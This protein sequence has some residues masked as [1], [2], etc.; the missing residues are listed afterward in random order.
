MTTAPAMSLRQSVVGSRA[1]RYSD[2]VELIWT[3]PTQW[4]P[5]RMVSL[6]ESLQTV[7]K[8]ESSSPGGSVSSGVN[9]NSAA[10]SALVGCG[11]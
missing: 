9:S 2:S 11:T 7:S 4:L 6:P 10:G 1:I 5:I 3:P 8:K